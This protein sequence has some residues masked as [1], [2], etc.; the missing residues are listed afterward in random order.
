MQTSSL[1]AGNCW[2]I[3]PY[4]FGHFVEEFFAYGYQLDKVYEEYSKNSIVRFIT[5]G[6][7]NDSRHKQSDHWCL[8]PLFPKIRFAVV[9]LWWWKARKK[10]MLF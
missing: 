6:S 10:L 2:K 1:E 9:G 8:F 3:C 5:N 7:A 4:K